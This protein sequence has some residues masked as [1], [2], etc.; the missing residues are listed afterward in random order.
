MELQYLQ[1][2]VESAV[3]SFTA[4]AV[5]LTPEEQENINTDIQ[6]AVIVTILQKQRGGADW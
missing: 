2:E 5:R 4:A 6:F 1:T 3:H